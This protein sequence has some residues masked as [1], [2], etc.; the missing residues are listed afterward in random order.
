MRC[1]DGVRV[2][3]HMVMSFFFFNFGIQALKRTDL[4]EGVGLEK[5]NE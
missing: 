3:L 1:L 4:R 2:R 5:R